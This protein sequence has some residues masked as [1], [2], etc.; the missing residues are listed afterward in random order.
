MC[1]RAISLYTDVISLYPET[2][3]KVKLELAS[4]YAE[5]YIDRTE[6]ANQIYENLLSSEQDP[7]ELQMLYFHY[8]TYKNFH[9]QDRNASIDYHKKAAEIPN[10]NKYGKKSFNILRKIEQR[11][12]NRRCAEILEFLENLSSHNE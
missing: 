12:R 9:I 5:S 2:S 7:Y 1:D 8:A 6:L 3:L 11:G 4:I 10:P